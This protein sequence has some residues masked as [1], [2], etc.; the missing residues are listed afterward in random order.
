MENAAVAEDPRVRALRPARGIDDFVADPVGR[1]CTGTTYVVWC[2]S[3]TL[4]GSTHWGRPSDRDVR[5]LLRLFECTRHPT[6]H[7][8]DVYMD[9]AAVEQLDWRALCVLSEY[10]ETRLATW[11][12]RIHRQS[13]VTPP[14]LVGLILAGVVPLLGPTYPMRFTASR[15]TALEW[16]ARADLPLVLEQ[17]D[18]I[19][20]HSR[21]VAWVVRRLH[22]Y[23]ERHL[24]TTVEDTARALGMSE[25]SL[26]RELKRAGTQYCVELTRARVK[27]ACLL[28]VQ[29]DEKVE[30]IARRVGCLSASRLGAIFR[31]EMGETPIGYRSRHRG[32]GAYARSRCRGRRIE[33]T[34]TT[35]TGGT[36]R[37]VVFGMAATLVGL[38]ATPASAG[39]QEAAEIFQCGAYSSC[40]KQVGK[41]IVCTQIGYAC[42]GSMAGARTSIDPTASA[43]FQIESDTSSPYSYLNFLG[44]YQGTVYACTAPLETPASQ[45]GWAGLLTGNYFTIK[46]DLDGNCTSATASRESYVAQ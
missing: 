45:P 38:F 44:E 43:A 37:T 35:T 34:N 31:G 40:V 6:L 10:L 32:G 33:M 2:A 28:L 22:A 29:T 17:I 19:V 21:G 26:Q 5:E 8:L 9:D 46:M 1:Y 25:R 16:L 20:A 14:G 30:C 36:M 12:A 4:C 13:V 24:A 27:Q 15:S 7:N 42:S 18:E 39:Q 11:A 41:G 3:P 23:L